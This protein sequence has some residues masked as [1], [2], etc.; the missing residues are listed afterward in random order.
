MA[1]VIINGMV[2]EGSF[3]DIQ[4]ILGVKSE[5]A[6]T[7][8]VTSQNSVQEYYN[9]ASLVQR[10]NY[11]VETTKKPYKQ[12]DVET[13]YEVEKMDGFFRIKNAINT[14]GK[15]Y[16]DVDGKEKQHRFNRIAYRIANDY[17]KELKN[18]PVY[19]KH[20]LEVEV[21]ISGKRKGWFAWGF[22][23]RKMCDEVINNILPKVVLAAE[24]ETVRKQMQAN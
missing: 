17:I 14:Y 1:K 2:V 8:V 5:S 13:R 9:S 24:I 19:G 16:I 10:Q 4:V 21:P 3:E 11:V 6:R 15:K 7:N 18:H 23:T 12:G 20:F 22:K